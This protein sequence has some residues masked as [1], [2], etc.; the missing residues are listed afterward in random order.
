MNLM[1]KYS[2]QP[3]NYLLYS[4]GGYGKTTSL[5]HLTQKLLGKKINGKTVVPIYI[6][7]SII[8]VQASLMNGNFLLNRINKY[9][10]NS[11]TDKAIVEMI[12]E[13]TTYDF[14]FILDGY[15]EV[16]NY[17]L[18]DGQTVHGHIAN[19]IY[20]LYQCENV[21]FI[22]SVRKKADLFRFQDLNDS[23]VYL[24]IQK[25][26]KKQVKDYLQISALSAQAE[27]LREIINSPFFLKMFK[28]LWDENKEEALNLKSKE[29]L[30]QKYFDIFEIHD[31]KEKIDN[32]AEVRKHILD[33][34]LPL[35]GFQVEMALMDNTE[36]RL[37][38]MDYDALLE[39]TLVGNS[40]SA[41]IT[42]GLVKSVLAMMN[43]IDKNLMFGH[44]LIGEY[45]GFRGLQKQAEYANSKEQV[46]Q[47]FELLHKKMCYIEEYGKD[48]SRR[49]QF[50]NLAEFI[51]GVYGD[52]YDLY[53]FFKGIYFTE[54]EA[55]TYAEMFAQDLAGVYDDLQQKKPA[56]EIG[57]KAITLLGQ[58]QDTDYGLA[59]KYNFLYYSVNKY[60]G[61]DP[62]WLLEQAKIHIERVP[63]EMRDK[64]YRKLKAKILS[65]FG[66][67]YCSVYKTDYHMAWQYH[68]QALEYRKKY[69]LPCFPSYKTLM[70]DCFHLREYA[71][72]YEYYKNAIYEVNNGKLLSTEN[73]G[74]DIPV[75]LAV[76]AMG[77][78]IPLIKQ[79]KDEK[80]RDGIIK[81]IIAQIE[82]AYEKIIES[83]RK[84]AKMLEILCGKIEELLEVETIENKS[85]VVIEQY[86]RK[87][88]KH[89]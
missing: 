66:S 29:D 78:E 59:D 55:I 63:N 48:F 84:D 74:Q 80:V 50:L 87:C 54:Q 5:Q 26:N 24:E 70:S 85:W 72:A 9:F 38:V 56:Y 68:N 25:L 1:D 73:T 86:H 67:Y 7:M 45:F 46:K 6:Q 89:F 39:H 88:T 35:I 53:D 17:I 51:E 58:V 8:N 22:I 32:L 31:E 44:Q 43:L 62:L 52:T 23:F 3:Q 28:V 75:D 61:K 60:K 4:D 15:N 21:H 10:N 11:V 20:V 57:W 77:S 13:S 19:D 41:N 34:V 83:A 37:A 76:Y 42:A 30:M 65:N 71:E 69:K 36:N 49:T 81:E 79:E 14:L 82:Y 27:H 33:S 2:M 16:N 64:G 12:N 40:L 47:F 18:K